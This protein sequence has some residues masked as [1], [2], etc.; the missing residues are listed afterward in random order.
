[1]YK[2][3]KFIFPS[4]PDEE[5][6]SRGG[7]KLQALSSKFKAKIIS[8][9]ENDIT[10]AYP[11]RIY[12][13]LLTEYSIKVTGI[14]S[15][16]TL[17]GVKLAL[18]RDL[19]PTNDT[20]ASVDEI[21]EAR[22][23]KSTRSY[24]LHLRSEHSAKFLF[25]SLKQ[26]SS[27]Q[28]YSIPDGTSRNVGDTIFCDP[29]HSLCVSPHYRDV[30]GRMML[31][32]SLM[33]PELG[34]IDD[35]YIEVVSEDVDKSKPVP[36]K[37][38]CMAPEILPFPRQIND[39]KIPQ[40]SLFAA[41]DDMDADVDHDNPGGIVHACTLRYT[42]GAEERKDSDP[43]AD[44]EIAEASSDAESNSQTI[45]PL[46]PQQ[47]NDTEICIKCPFGLDCARSSFRLC[48]LILILL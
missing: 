38:Y 15:G 40:N 25:D 9:N 3:L 20:L 14:E 12:P 1:M 24:Q 37:L 28:S 18:K 11:N 27:I 32:M 5:N 10:V 44:T 43:D 17:K 7:V 8:A 19:P 48:S 21:M 6:A 22:E 30:N 39:A 29:K 45:V 42:E 13:E 31:M 41:T 4:L 16:L 34:P 23:D 36:F 33:A 46:A 26:Y 47:T 2:S 35:W